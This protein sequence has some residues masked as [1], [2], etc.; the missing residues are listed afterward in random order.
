[1]TRKVTDTLG[2][3]LSTIP[4]NRRLV[5]WRGLFLTC[6]TNGDSKSHTIL[7]CLMG[8][9]RLHAL[10]VPAVRVLFH[11]KVWGGTDYHYYYY[12][13][14]YFFFWGGGGGGC[15]NSIILPPP[16]HPAPPPHGGTESFRAFI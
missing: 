15:L 2:N 13:Y 3:Q 6:G 5:G 16:S 7:T 1:M 9:T 12:Y 4:I 11:L 14:Y 10:P 8:K